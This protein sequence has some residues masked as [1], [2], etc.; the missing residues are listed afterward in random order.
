MTDISASKVK[1]LREISGAGM[2]DCKKALLESNA[3]IPQAM[4]YLRKS[5]IAK[6]EKWGKLQAQYM[7]NV[8]VLG[9]QHK[10]TRFKP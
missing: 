8:D 7:D 9:I 6:A 5:G 10:I 1:E 2:M 3:D 4:D